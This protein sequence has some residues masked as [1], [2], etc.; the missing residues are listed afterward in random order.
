MKVAVVACNVLE[1]LIREGL[2]EDVHAIFLDPGLHEQ[3]QRMPPAI[4]DALHQITEPSLVLVGYGLCGNGL[5]GVHAGRHTLV[6][7]RSAD[8]ISILLG[9]YRTYQKEVAMEPGTIYV[10]KG[11]IECGGE[12]LAEYKKYA[13][14]YGDETAQWLID[15]QYKH[16]RRLCFIASQPGDF[17]KYGDYARK[18]AE[19]ACLEY[20][21]KIGTRDYVDSLLAQ[22]SGPKPG[23]DFVIV[24]PGEVVEQSSFFR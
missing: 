13:E 1:D 6:I 20:E 19:F 11:W 21:E 15:E 16:Y 2:E 10:S 18:V 22:R 7:P 23:E 12:P 17:Q 8:C 5:A 14:K 24:R 3:P 9:S 4:E